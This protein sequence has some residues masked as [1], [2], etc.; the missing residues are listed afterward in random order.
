MAENKHKKFQPTKKDFSK[1]Y[2]HM[3]T[4]SS[5]T[6]LIMLLTTALVNATT[7]TN[8]EQDEL[9][10]QKSKRKKKDKAHSTVYIN[11]G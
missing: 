1:S 3:K 8:H 7:W 6:S 9:Y 4:G 10:I 11:K 2:E 5:N